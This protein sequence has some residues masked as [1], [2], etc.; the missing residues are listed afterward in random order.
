M[1]DEFEGMKESEKSGAS[2]QDIASSLKNIQDPKL[3]Q[4][5]FM[6]FMTKLSKGQISI[7][8]NQVIEKEGEHEDEETEKLVNEFESIHGKRG[9]LS[10][11]WMEEFENIEEQEEWM[12]EWKEMYGDGTQWLRQYE[13][14][15]AEENPYM[16][17]PEA[18]EKGMELFNDGRTTQAILAF[19]AEVQRNPQNSTCWRFLGQAHAES[20]RDNKAIACLIRATEAN[21]ADLD[22]LM[23][24]AVSYT[25]D[26]FKD[27]ALDTLKKYLSMNPK[28]SSLVPP[29]Q[30]FIRDVNRPFED[31]H[32]EVTHLYLEAARSKSLEPDADIQTALGL[33]FNL[34][35]EYDKAVDCFQTALQVRSNDYLLWNKL[36][37]TLANSNRSEEALAC[38]FNA[39]KLKPSYVRAR[40]NLGIS[41]MALKDNV[42]AAKY[43]LGALSLHP[44]A[45]HIWSNLQMVFMSM[46]RDDLVERCALANVDLFR[47]EFEF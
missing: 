18:F 17:H 9:T 7:V 44:H 35:S 26:L 34:S 13:F 14:V 12:R 33:L 16:G 23:A 38:Y 22:S 24:L 4:S 25:N 8:D 42:N 39:L 6:K 21:P 36:G 29:T 11:H 27:Q 28:Y 1:L 45:Q 47:D 31:Y 46:G 20:D 19:E 41:Y 10:E 2:L 5:D 37:A 43:F 40:A 32:N 15:P 3:Q 30:E